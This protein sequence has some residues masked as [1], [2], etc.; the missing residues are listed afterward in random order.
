MTARRG[1]ARNRGGSREWLVLAPGSAGLRTRIRRARRVVLHGIGVVAAGGSSL[2]PETAGGADRAAVRIP[3]DRGGRRR[4]SRAAFSLG[5]KAATSTRQVDEELGS[6]GL[7][8]PNRRRSEGA[9]SLDCAEAT[10]GDR[11]EP[12][13]SRIPLTPPRCRSPDAGTMHPATTP[14]SRTSGE[15][16][17]LQCRRD[18]PPTWGDTSPRVA[19][20]RD[21]PGPFVVG[22]GCGAGVPG[23]YVK[24]IGG[25]GPW[26][27]GFSLLPCPLSLF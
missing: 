22:A 18:T 17:G 5:G 25:R 15:C 6:I 4:M 14:R 20:C 7:P 3:I 12:P 9:V 10:I 1:V 24:R 19:S 21:R 16:E 23:A 27:D 11:P 2:R 26:S 8:P 13:G